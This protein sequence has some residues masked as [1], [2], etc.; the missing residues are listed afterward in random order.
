[1][2][3]L[4][5]PS[6]RITL[7]VLGVFALW[8]LLNHLWLM[9]LPMATYHLISFVVEVA[10]AM[11]ALLALAAQYERF[12]AEQKRAEQLGTI[13]ATALAMHHDIANPLDGLTGSLEQ[14]YREFSRNAERS[15]LAME[16]ALRQAD[17]LE[18]VVQSLVR[19]LD[20]AETTLRLIEGPENF[21]LPETAA[22]PPSRPVLNKVA[23][24]GSYRL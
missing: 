20:P 17:R 8:Q 10:I 15:R 21:S 13:I 12:R 19:T 23:A 24:E 11:A 2:H 6:W 16:T 4:Q 18:R 14:A 5:P 7:A 3:N 22:R 1:M 9:A